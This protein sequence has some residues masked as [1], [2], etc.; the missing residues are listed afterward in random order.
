MLFRSD[1]N[2]LELEK[3]YCPYFLYS[4]KRYAAKLYEKKGDAVVFKKIDVRRR[5][6]VASGESLSS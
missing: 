2:E 5:D 1:P 4:K 3:V 6:R